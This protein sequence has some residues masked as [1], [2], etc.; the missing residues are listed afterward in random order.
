MSKTNFRVAE[1]FR[2]ERLVVRD[3]L[4]DER[5]E[6]DRVQREFTM[7]KGESRTYIEMDLSAEQIIH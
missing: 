4:R 3:D 1:K 6:E 5:I 2:H 7:G